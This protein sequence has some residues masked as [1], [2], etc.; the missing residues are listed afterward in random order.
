[1]SIYVYGETTYGRNES[2]NEGESTHPK[3]RGKRHR[4]KRPGETTH[5]QHGS[6]T[7]GPK[8]ISVRDSSAW[9]FRPIFQSGT[10]RPT[11]VG[12][13]GP[14]FCGVGGQFIVL[15]CLVASKLCLNYELKIN[16]CK[17]G[18]NLAK[19]PGPRCPA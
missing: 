16:C 13:L 19:C 4:A 11:L 8:T 14:F 5:G 10:A 2:P 3:T 17:D 1:M 6:G 12:P 7:P 15:F 18:P 9:T